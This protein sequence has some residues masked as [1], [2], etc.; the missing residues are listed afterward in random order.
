MDILMTDVATELTVS[1]VIRILAP[2]C[3]KSEFDF[4][5]P[6]WPPDVFAIVATLLDRSSGYRH[7]VCAEWPPDVPEEVVHSWVEW[8]KHLGDTWRRTSVDDPATLP[9]QIADWWKIVL[10]NAAYP[11]RRLYESKD[12]CLAL[13]QLSAAADEAC[14][15]VVNI[16]SLEQEHDGDTQFHQRAQE[17]LLREEGGASLCYAIHGSRARVLPK[18]RTSQKG[19]TLRSFSLNICLCPSGEVEPLWRNAPLPR[20]GEG[21]SLNLLI[22]PWPKIIAPNAFQRISDEEHSIE[23]VDGHGM[24]R[25]DTPDDAA[26]QLQQGTEFLRLIR[27]AQKLCG[28]I[29]GILLPEASLTPEQF[30]RLKDLAF[31]ADAFLISGVYESS[32]ENP[33]STNSVR[34]SFPIGEGSSAAEYEQFKHHRWQLEQAQLANYGLAAQLDPTQ[35]WWEGIDIRDRKLNFLAVQEWLT[36]S[37]LICEDLARQDP[38]SQ[39]LRTVGP[40][41]VIALLMDGPQLKT[42]WPNRY[43]MVLADDPGCAVLSVTSLGMCQLSRPLHQQQTSRVIALWKDDRNGA[44]EIE[45][46]KDAGAVVLTLYNDEIVEYSADGRCDDY[47][48]TAVYLGGVHPVQAVSA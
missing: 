37:V 23:M 15:L 26:L 35:T 5:A 31:A 41:L 11:V 7:A 12:C 43:A 42:R 36:M 47:K 10:A 24:F 18:F 32:V 48:T 16:T 40:N 1:E 25:V 27:S 28:R 29:D 14:R 13:L 45:L 21:H 22:V 46:P 17:L 9:Q 44:V 39:M 38:V 20:T 8:M 6:T 30:A 19:L 3:W 33:I 34:M 4:S 2:S